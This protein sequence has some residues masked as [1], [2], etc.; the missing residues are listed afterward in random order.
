MIACRVQREP[1]AS[2]PWAGT[3]PLTAVIAAQ[4]GFGCC[5]LLPHSVPS[6]KQR[7]DHFEPGLGKDRIGVCP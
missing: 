5:V 2:G 7:L 3:A 1:N 6:N 4:P